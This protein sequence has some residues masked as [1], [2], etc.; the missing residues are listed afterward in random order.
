MTP[1][2]EE[3]VSKHGEKHVKTEL[4]IFAIQ[5]IEDLFE[6]SIYTHFASV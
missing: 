3:R 1:N 2:N 4:R 6:R 5:T